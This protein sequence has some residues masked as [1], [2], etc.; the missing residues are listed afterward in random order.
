MR[1]VG[2][3][4]M[5]KVVLYYLRKVR[6]NEA[7]R[8][9]V[10]SRAT[11][12]L[13]AQDLG[14]VILY[15]VLREISYVLRYKRVESVLQAVFK[16]CVSFGKIG[17]IYHSCTCGERDKVTNVLDKACYGAIVIHY[18]VEEG[19]VSVSDCLLRVVRVD[20]ALKSLLPHG[21]YG[22]AG[23][24]RR[25][26]AG[27]DGII[28][29]PFVLDLFKD[30]GFKSFLQLSYYASDLGGIYREKGTYLRCDRN[31]D[32]VL[33]VFDSEPLKVQRRSVLLRR[34]LAAGR[35]VR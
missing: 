6:R 14:D 11:V 19:D 15:R 22:N 18:I 25:V 23:Y 13:T 28:A 35:I 7:I 3:G 9:S 33:G 8:K 4:F 21:I 27:C 17:R 20:I 31:Y 5:L 30:D 26:A 34:S 32:L 10:D 2:V 24:R 16:L 1:G 12:R 29:Y